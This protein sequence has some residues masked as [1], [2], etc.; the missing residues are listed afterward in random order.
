M[1]CPRCEENSLYKIKFKIT[2][3]IASLCSNCDWFWFDGE[4]IDIFTGH[5][6]E[7]YMNDQS[8]NT[9]FEY[10]D[11]KDRDRQ[12]IIDEREREAYETL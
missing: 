2:N 3:K 7:K 11:E 8:S 6:L 10:L 9:F 1:N 12:E 5:M 4:N